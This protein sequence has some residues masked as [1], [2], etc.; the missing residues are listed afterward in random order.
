MLLRQHR[1]AIE[2]AILAARHAQAELRFRVLAALTACECEGNFQIDQAA[3][4]LLALPLP[5]AKSIDE[6]QA[7]RETVVPRA[8]P[9]DDIDETITSRRED[10]LTNAKEAPLLQP[11]AT[12]KGTATERWLVASV[13]A[14]VTMHYA[15]SVGRRPRGCIRRASPRRTLARSP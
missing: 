1:Q 12:E 3:R 13:D 9:D 5:T 14:I 11:L 8:V 15:A 10:T 2:R 4:S 7:Y 6:L